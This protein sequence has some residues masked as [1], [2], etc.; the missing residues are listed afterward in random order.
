MIEA[1]RREVIERIATCRLFIG[2][3]TGFSHVA[4]LY[5]NVRQIALHD[6]ANTER[7]NDPTFDHQ[8]LSRERVIAFARVLGIEVE[9]TEYMAFPNKAN[10]C[11]ILFDRN[12][13]DGRTIEALATAIEDI[14]G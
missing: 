6:R 5:D 10:V 12:G 4:G 8:R 14:N 11:R 9:R 3:D 7:H 2:G 1:P 13:S